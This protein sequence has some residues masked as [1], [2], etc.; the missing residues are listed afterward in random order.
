MRKSIFTILLRHSARSSDDHQ[1]P[2][3]FTLRH[4]SHHHCG[5]GINVVPSLIHAAMRLPEPA[6]SLHPASAAR[7]KVSRSP[8]T[9]TLPPGIMRPVSFQGVH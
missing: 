9:T 2:S 5:E 8:V 6:P 4:A 3:P 1:A 7:P